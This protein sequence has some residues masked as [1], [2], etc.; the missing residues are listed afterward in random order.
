MTFFSSQSYMLITVIITMT[1]LFST[2]AKIVSMATGN[3][4][5]LGVQASL[6]SVILDSIPACISFMSH[7]CLP[8][9]CSLISCICSVCQFWSTVASMMARYIHLAILMKLSIFVGNSILMISVITSSPVMLCFSKCVSRCSDTYKSTLLVLRNAFTPST[10]STIYFHWFFCFCLV[11]R[12]KI[13]RSILI[14]FLMGQDIL[15][16]RFF[17]LLCS[18]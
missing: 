8:Y 3:S 13:L 12:N 9:L 7:P 15:L 16:P 10:R 14:A 2:L 4:T 17:F 6:T 1:V 5:Y 11:R 18:V